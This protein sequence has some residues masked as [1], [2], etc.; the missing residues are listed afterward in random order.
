MGETIIQEGEKKNNC[1]I[2]FKGTTMAYVG[3]DKVMRPLEFVEQVGTRTQ[4]LPPIIVTLAEAQQI[5][6]P[7]D[8]ILAEV[9][10]I[11][12]RILQADN[13]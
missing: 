3:E 8:D 1:Y 11:L 2:I 6:Q 10:E 9:K 13:D 7:L 4:R 5:Y 12:M